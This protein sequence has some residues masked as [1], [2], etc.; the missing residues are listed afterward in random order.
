MSEAWSTMPSLP[1]LPL[2]AA[3]AGG[4]ALDSGTEGDDPAHPLSSHW[5]PVAHPTWG[6]KPLGEEITKQGAWGVVRGEEARTWRSLCAQT[7]SL[8]TVGR[9]FGKCL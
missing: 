2:L 6:K 4:C 7:L 3:W 1:V 8:R 5:A 9:N